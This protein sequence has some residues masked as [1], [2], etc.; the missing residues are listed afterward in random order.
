M[1][2]ANIQN[3]AE[4]YGIHP[5]LD[6]ALDCLNPE[7]LEQ[8]ATEKTLLDGEKLFVTK[9]HLET[10]P[11]EETFFEAHRQYLDIQVVTQ[12]Q[13]R[14]EIAHPDT[15]TL[16]EHSGDFYGYTGTGE[17]TVVLRPGNFLIVFP[18]DAHRLK[19]PVGESG[20]P[21]TRVVFKIKV[22]N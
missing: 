8:A 6:K 17:Q 21:F 11:E 5:E 15:L 12:G 7:F 18:G 1:I 14:V 3:K 16:T 13:E 10:V 22:Y 9:F 20:K 19:L 4:Y 2:V